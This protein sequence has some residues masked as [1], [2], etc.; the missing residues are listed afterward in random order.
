MIRP[1]VQRVK[2]R[3]SREN[4]EFPKR[5]FP[6]NVP[7]AFTST[8]RESKVPEVHKDRAKDEKNNGIRSKIIRNGQMNAHNFPIGNVDESNGN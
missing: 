5:P 7:L 2:P 1:T 8:V 4:V 3:H 6:I